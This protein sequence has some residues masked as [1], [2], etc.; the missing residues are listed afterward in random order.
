MVYLELLIVTALALLF[1]A[2][3][4]QDLSDGPYPALTLIKE[5]PEPPLLAETPS[6]PLRLFFR[7]I[8]YLILG[9][10]LASIIWSR[11]A[12]R[13]SDQTAGGQMLDGLLTLVVILD[14][15]DHHL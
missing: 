11:R 5:L 8:W 1:S 14:A 6:Q 4:S 7:A 13:H 9:I 12:M 10:W 2:F 15:D 3:T